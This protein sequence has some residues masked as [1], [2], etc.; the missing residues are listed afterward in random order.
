MSAVGSLTN[1]KGACSTLKPW[2][3]RLKSHKEGIQLT[4]I[5]VS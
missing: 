1:V 4:F 5:G 2:L 3:R